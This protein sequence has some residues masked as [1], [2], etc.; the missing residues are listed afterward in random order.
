MR[1]FETDS[2]AE[3]QDARIA[4]GEREVLCQKADCMMVRIHARA[5][6]QRIAEL[7]AERDQ[8]RA[9]LADTQTLAEARHEKFEAEVSR[10]RAELETSDG[11]VKDLTAEMD[12]Q[13]SE[14]PKLRAVAEAARKVASQIVECDEPECGLC[15]RENALREALAK[16]EEKS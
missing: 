12:R 14:I 16:L 6:E 1:N 2:E 4:N 11:A 8:L 7:E 10:L 13:L 3:R 9:D 5:A 15:Q